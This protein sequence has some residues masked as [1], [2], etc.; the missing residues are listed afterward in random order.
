[1]KVTL[2]GLRGSPA[3]TLGVMLTF[4]LGVGANAAM[5]SLIDRLMLRP[6]AFLRDPASV[7]R[8]YLYR[9]RD[10]V[11]TETG[12]QY[13]RNADIARSSTSFSDIAMHS[14]RRLAVGVGQ[15]AREM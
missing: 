14:L 10:G 6:P 12:G 11:E 8:A 2:R 3:F 5:F 15:D 4:A 7:N 9:T 13:V 1:A